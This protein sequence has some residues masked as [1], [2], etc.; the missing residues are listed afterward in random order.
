GIAEDWFST[1]Q[2]IDIQNAQPGFDAL[3]IAIGANMNLTGSGDPLRVGVIRTSSSLLPMLGVRP[4]AG[5]L[6]GAEED[7]PGHATTAII[8]DGLWPG[9]FGRDKGVVGRSIA[10]NGQPYQVIGILPPQFS[11]PREVLPTLGVAED[12][13]VFLPLPLGAAAATT[14]GHEDYNIVG[15]LA[16]GVTVGRLQ[17]GLDTLTARL[18]RDHPDVY[19]PN[20]GLTFSAVPL[21][22]QVVGHVRRPL[23]ML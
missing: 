9:G 16:P 8:S 11:L 20:G 22:D 14:R 1:A 10:L 6:F 7:V 23:L 13:E 3:A 5:R 18:R 12:G 19:P 15:R 17:A 2:Y 21:L 4:A